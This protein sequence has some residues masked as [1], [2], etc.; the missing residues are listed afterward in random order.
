[1]SLLLESRDTKTHRR[2]K[3]QRKAQDETEV[4]LPQAR[5]NWKMSEKEEVTDCLRTEEHAPVNRLLSDL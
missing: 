1:M 3:T 5:K 2:G 4:K